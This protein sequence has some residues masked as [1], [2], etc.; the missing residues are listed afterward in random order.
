[1]VVKE[2]EEEEVVVLKVYLNQRGNKEGLDA[3]G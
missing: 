3:A 2:E 1:M